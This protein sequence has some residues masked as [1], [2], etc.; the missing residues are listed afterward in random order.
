VPAS[1]SVDFYLRLYNVEHA[2]TLPSKFYLTVAGATNSWQEGVGLDMETYSDKD[3]A[4]WIDRKLGSAWAIVGGDFHTGAYAGL[5]AGTN[6]PW[7]DVYFEKGTEDLELNITS[8]V[9]EWIATNEAATVNNGIGI[10]LSGTYEAYNSNSAGTHTTSSMHNL[11]GAKRSYYTKKFS[12]RGTEYFFKRP[13]IEAR[14]NSATKDDTGNFFLSSSLLGA[15]DNLN[16]L[17]LYN[18]FGGQLKDIPGGTP[19]YLY[20]YSGSAD[21]SIVDTTASALFLPPGGDVSPAAGTNHQ[22]AIGGRVSTG[23]YSASFAYNSSSIITVFPVWT[24]GPAGAPVQLQTGSAVTVQAHNASSYNPSPNYV[25][26]IRNIK[27]SYSTNENARFRVTMRQKDWSPTIYTVA[28][29]TPEIQLIE[30]ASF[31]VIRMVDNLEAISYGTGSGLYTQLSYDV[32]G[33][34]FDLDMS[35]LE[36]GY[37]YGIQLAYYTNQDWAEQPEIFKFRVE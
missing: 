16:T 14:W 31:K 12:A 37:M 24:K 9:E 17:Y 20:L 18:Y 19:T 8:L 21:N 26:N 28:S 11:E 29:A 36:P 2:S 27:P 23:I 22:R 15:E 6:L 5:P 33:S 30:S 1:G 7:Y 35:M 13:T 25:T 34:Y 10:F 4:N 3:E 32:S